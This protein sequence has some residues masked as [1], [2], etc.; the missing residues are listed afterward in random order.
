[1]K[2]SNKAPLKSEV[3]VNN[4]L[5]LGFVSKRRHNN[6]CFQSWLYLTID[7]LYVFNKTNRYFA[8]VVILWFCL[9]ASK[10]F[11]FRKILQK[12]LKKMVPN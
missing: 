2:S 7:T 3:A 12:N 4:K 5:Q 10:D 1:L 11:Y 8:Q 6:I 9:N